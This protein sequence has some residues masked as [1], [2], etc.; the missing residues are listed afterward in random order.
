M[1]ELFRRVLYVYLIE[2]KRLFYGMGEM[3][4]LWCKKCRQKSRSRTGERLLGW[5][6]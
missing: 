5:L 6:L 1:Q 4:V 3:M 2:N